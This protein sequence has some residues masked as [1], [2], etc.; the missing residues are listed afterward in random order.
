MPVTSFQRSILGLAA[1]L[2]LSLLAACGS[3]SDP[4]S[5]SW[6]YISAAIL[7]PNCATTSCHSRAAAVSGL[8]FSDAE[9]GFISLTGLWIWIVDPTG[10]AANGCQRVGNTVVCQREHRSLV[11]PFDP[12]QSRLVHMLRAEG[13]SRMPPDR[14]LAQADIR[15]VESWILHGARRSDTTPD[16]SLDAASADAAPADVDASAN[17]A[18]ARTGAAEGDVEGD[19]DGDDSGSASTGSGREESLE[20]DAGASG[21]SG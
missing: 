4:R 14:P 5:A 6:S 20:T 16:A 10:T 1:A 15:L 8:D 9:R 2:S 7:A 13:A 12:A 19:A 21:A 17:D 11:V 3:R 18:D